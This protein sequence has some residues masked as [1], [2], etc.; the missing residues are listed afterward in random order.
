MAPG[1]SGFFR[2]I[3]GGGG[4]AGA[5]KEGD[6]TEYNGYTIRP[7]PRR[8][9][10]GWLTVGTIAKEFPEGVKEHK[11]IRADTSSSWDD[12]VALSVRKAKQII[13]EQGDR[14][15]RE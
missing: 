2:S 3:F 14:M 11:F 7:A 5:A 12:A 8:E 9:A 13:D 15:F 10:A 4:A 1:I 6:A